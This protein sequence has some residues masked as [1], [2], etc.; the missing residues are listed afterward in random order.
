M[1]DVEN[2][3]FAR[4]CYDVRERSWILINLLEEGTVGEKLERRVGWRSLKR[5]VLYALEGQFIDLIRETSD[6]NDRRCAL[7]IPTN[8]LFVIYVPSYVGS[9]E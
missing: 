3:D 5:S 6:I 7:N 8:Y 4:H 9:W 1:V 2:C